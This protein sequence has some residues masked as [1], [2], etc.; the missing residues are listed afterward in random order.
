M[1][2]GII[3]TRILCRGCNTTV[4]VSTDHNWHENSVGLS[5]ATNLKPTLSKRQSR[6]G[7]VSLLLSLAIPSLHSLGHVC[8]H[9]YFHLPTLLLTFVSYENL[10]A[11]YNL[12]LLSIQI[13]LHTL[14]KYFQFFII[15]EVWFIIHYSFLYMHVI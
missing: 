10:Y 14:M 11:F 6:I 7:G 2:Q 1:C 5:S 12:I 8:F 15:I 13:S 9:N 4:T 3:S